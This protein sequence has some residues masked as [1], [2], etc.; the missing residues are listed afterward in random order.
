MIAVVTPKANISCPPIPRAQVTAEE[1][2]AVGRI[3]IEHFKMPA[4]TTPL[5]YLPLFQP[6]VEDPTSQLDVLWK[7]SLHLQSPRPSWSGTMQMLHRGEPVV[8]P[9]RVQIEITGARHLSHGLG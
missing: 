7:I 8:G 2:A 1:I 3:S 5:T 9:A 6:R 4:A